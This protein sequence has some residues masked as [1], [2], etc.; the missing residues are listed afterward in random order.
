MTHLLIFNSGIS[1]LALTDI[2][3]YFRWPK[4]NPDVCGTCSYWMGLLGFYYISALW[5]LVSR[6][7]QTLGNQA[8]EQ[9]RH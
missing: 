2:K 7:V 1:V 3:A 6:L 4:I 9:L 8:T 5:F